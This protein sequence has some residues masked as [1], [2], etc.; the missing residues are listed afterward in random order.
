MF[1]T[2]TSVG[3]RVC[4]KILP[5]FRAVAVHARKKLLH[6]R[7]FARAASPARGI[8]LAYLELHVQSM[9]FMYEMQSFLLLKNVKCLI[10]DKT[11]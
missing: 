7:Q 3:R 2:L 8:A 9:I 5:L 10:K 11:G 6:E 1:H 4:L